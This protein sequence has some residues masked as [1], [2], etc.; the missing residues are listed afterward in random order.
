MGLMRRSWWREPAIILVALLLAGGDAACSPPPKA[1]EFRSEAGRFSVMTP[2]ALEEHTRNVETQIG[3]I[4]SRMFVGNSGGIGYM[5][6]Y[7]D[8]PDEVIQTSDPE[9]M[10]DGSRNGAVNNVNGKLVMET[11]ISLA[12]HPGR[13]FVAEAKGKNQEDLTIKTRLFLVKN[14]LY[15]VLTA[16]KKEKAASSEMNQFLQSFKLI[17]Q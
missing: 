10:L 11:R 1:R 3:T 6:G 16:A 17:G 4:V 9:E 7:S 8:Y 13:E 5:V 14:R 2:A 15:M 12:G